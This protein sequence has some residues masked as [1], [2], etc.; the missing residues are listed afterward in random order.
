[1]FQNQPP[2]TDDDVNR[3]DGLLA[4]AEERRVEVEK[5]AEDRPPQAVVVR[6]E[7]QNF[8]LV[9]H[10]LHAFDFFDAPL[11]VFFQCRPRHLPPQV[12]R[13]VR[14]DVAFEP[15][16]DAEERQRDKLLANLFYQ[17]GEIARIILRAWP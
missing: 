8:D 1:S 9:Y 11:R 2:T 4:V 14:F 13:A 16:E 10:F 5:L 6:R 12:N 17:V 3:G 15:I 7:R